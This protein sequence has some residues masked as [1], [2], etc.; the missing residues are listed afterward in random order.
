MTQSTFIVKTQTELVEHSEFSKTFMRWCLGS[1]FV[2]AGLLLAILVVYALAPSPLIM[3]GIGGI[4]ASFVYW[5][6]LPCLFYAFCLFI[7]SVVLALIAVLKYRKGKTGWISYSLIVLTFVLSSFAFLFLMMLEG[8]A[9]WY[10]VEL[11]YNVAFLNCMFLI[12]GL[13]FIWFLVWMIL[14]YRKGRMK[15][16]SFKAFLC[17][18]TGFVMAIAPIVFMVAIRWV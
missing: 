8:L 10:Y 2:L 7:V 9:N 16:R 18:W 3:R 1:G 15:Y 6:T 4:R 13:S 12:M 5:A 14:L 11:Y 17:R